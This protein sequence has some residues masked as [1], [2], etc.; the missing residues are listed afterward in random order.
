MIDFSVNSFV[1]IKRVNNIH[2]VL[3]CVNLFQVCNVAWGLFA[4]AIVRNWLHMLVHH[5][6]LTWK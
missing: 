6:S 2:V 1:Y 4:L 3:T 5:C